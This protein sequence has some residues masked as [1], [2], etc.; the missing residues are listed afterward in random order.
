MSD[1]FAHIPLVTPLNAAQLRSVGVPDGWGFGMADRVRFHELDALNHV[2][3]VA[4]FRWF[5][6]MRIVYF[7]HVHVTSY[8]D[9]DPQVVVASN[10]ARYVKP[11]HLGDDYV[12]TTRTK[13]YRNSSFMMEYATFV[14]GELMCASESLIVTLEHD[15]VTKRALR[16]ETI[17]A[18]KAEG[19][20]GPA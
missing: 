11:M 13:S 14:R 10:Y 3:N 15:G 2:N 17:A 18:F 4:Y 9:G 5:E 7:S 8:D 6:T 20:S 12:V 1:P 19:A 16:P